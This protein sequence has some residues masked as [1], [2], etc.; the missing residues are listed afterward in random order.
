M[1]SVTR[2]QVTTLASTFWIRCTRDIFLLE[3]LWMMNLAKSSR[4]PTRDSAMVRVASST[5]LMLPS[6]MEPSSFVRSENGTTLPATFTD[7][8]VGMTEATVWLLRKM[9]ASHLSGL[10]ARPLCRNQGWSYNRQVSRQVIADMHEVR[11]MATY[12]CVSSAYCC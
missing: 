12:S 3:A 6:R 9:M 5:T 10:T 4:D 11:Q 8:P 2:V 7:P 1:W